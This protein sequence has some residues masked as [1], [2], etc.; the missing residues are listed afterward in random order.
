[1]KLITGAIALNTNSI[2]ADEVFNID[3]LTWQKDESWGNYKV[4][5][6]VSP[7]NEVTLREAAKYSDNIYFAQAA[8]KIGS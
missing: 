8:L 7:Y 2:T 4:T 5:R 6:V 3:G 1:M